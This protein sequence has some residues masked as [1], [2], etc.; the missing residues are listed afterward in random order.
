MVAQA[1][2]PAPLPVDQQATKEQITKLF[3]VMRLRQTM[4]SLMKSLPA[5]M[6]Q[7]IEVQSKQMMQEA[8]RWT[9]HPAGRD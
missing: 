6:Q 8:G 5:M 3:E 9:I 7:Q 1:P 2:T 4:D